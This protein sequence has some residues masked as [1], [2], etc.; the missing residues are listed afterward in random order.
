MRTFPI[1]CTLIVILFSTG[2]DPI[3]WQRV[4]LQLR[5]PPADK[6]SITL[7]SPDTKEALEILD[8]VFVRHGFVLA[9]GYSN[10][11]D[12]G[13]IRLYSKQILN[14]FADGNNHT[15]AVSCRVSLNSTG[16]FVTFG[17]PT[18]S[19]Y[20]RETEETYEDV[21]STLTKRYGKKFVR[22]RKSGT[23]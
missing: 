22:S 10:Q 17:E 18:L 5:N 23:S 2:C 15:W 8:S 3:G 16:I 9:E 4:R 14:T 6:S 1:T 12:H 19:G 20:N 21:G 7:D 13:Y 11:Q